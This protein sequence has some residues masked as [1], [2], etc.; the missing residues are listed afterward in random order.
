MAVIVGTNSY[1]D[2]IG[3]SEYALDR[4]ITISGDTTVL[5]I[6]AMDWLEIQPF[7]GNE[8]DSSQSLTF[9]RDITDDE[10]PDN[11]ITAQYVA[12][13]LIDSGEDILATVSQSVKREKVGTIEVEYQDN[14]TA[15]K[16]YPQLAGLV[17]RYLSNTGGSFEVSRG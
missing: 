12:A 7:A 6:S 8:T 14:T 11:I 5:L 13:L 10:T 4:G 17:S 3:L 16:T 1:G 15:V 9:P 2:E